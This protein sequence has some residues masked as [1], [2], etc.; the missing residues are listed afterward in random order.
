MMTEARTFKRHVDLF[1]ETLSVEYGLSENTGQAYRSDLA[2]FQKFLGGKN[3]HYLS[4]NQETLLSYIGFLKEQNY[5]ISSQARCVSALRRFYGFLQEEGVCTENP[6]LLIRLPKSQ[7]PLPRILEMTDVETLIQKAWESVQMAHQTLGAQ[8][9]A[10]RLYAFIELLYGT[11]MRISELVSLPLEGQWTTSSSLY[12]CGKGG[13]ERMLPLSEY[14]QNAIASYL[15]CRHKL[16]SFAKNPFLFPAHSRTG[17]VTRQFFARELK[18]LARQSGI[19]PEA[20]SPH[21]LRHAFASHLLQNG[22]D[23]RELQKLLGHSD[24]SS[25]QIYTHVMRDEMR[26]LV[27]ACHPLSGKR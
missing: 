17:H 11:G 8:F 14:T 7:K 15:V 25:T 2:H 24:I 23:L 9:R 6:A 5:C 10:H 27:E 20:V 19:E 13:K 3:K 16:S 26:M 18:E 1:L 21:V 12:I 22:I 4:V